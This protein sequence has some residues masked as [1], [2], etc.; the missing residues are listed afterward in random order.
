MSTE[1]IF[2]CRLSWL[3]AEQGGTTT[4]EAYSREYRVEF[5][6]KAPLHGTAAPEFLGE[7]TLHNPE[8][9]LVAA[10]AGCHCLS[11]LALC[12]RSGITVVAYEDRARGTMKVVDKV[13]RF[14]EVVLQPRVAVLA[15]SDVEL[16]KRL[17]EKAHRQC[18]IAQSVNF[19]VT[20][21]PTIITE[22]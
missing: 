6:G 12:S 9:L 7:A 17:H 15:G 4:Y 19:P 14:A 18:F 3:G 2:E 13:L 11:Y 20:N 22:E 5:E 16:A 1:H 10:L 21:E 8:D